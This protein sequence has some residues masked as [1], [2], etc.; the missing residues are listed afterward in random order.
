VLLLVLAGLMP[1]AAQDLQ[2]K[3]AEWSE[4]LAEPTPARRRGA[5]REIAMWD[6]TLE[7]TYDLVFQGL[8]DPDPETRIAAGEILVRT[9]SD[10]RALADLVGLAGPVQEKDT[11]MMALMAIARVP[12]GAA[13]AL[14]TL[15]SLESDPDVG[16][17][18]R[19]A[20]EAVEGRQAWIAAQGAAEGDPTPTEPPPSAPTPAPSPARRG[21]RGEL[22]LGLFALGYGMLTVY[23]RFRHPDRLAKLAA[24][25]QK[26]GDGV[27]SAVHWAAYTVVPVLVGLVLIAVGLR[28]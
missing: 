9:R 23:L 7:R 26:W 16:H 4:R 3:R 15:R 8:S 21:P 11:R 24:M 25:K 13:D 27:G 1:A 14:D 19:Y 22:W 20:A 28:G 10:P 2:A 6:P 5:L 18:A 17:V 12:E